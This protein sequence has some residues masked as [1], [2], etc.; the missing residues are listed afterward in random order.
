MPRPRKWKRVCSLP[1][2]DMFGPLRQDAGNRE[3]L[4]MS[5]EEFETI[6]LIDQEGLT[7]DEAAL[8][9]DVARGTVQRLYSDARFKLAETLVNG[10]LLKIE[11]GDYRLYPDQESRRGCGQCRRSR[12]GRRAG[13]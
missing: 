12:C 8:R 3:V 11:G 9:M 13:E 2:S 1:E 7:Q 10:S 4:K 5:V 6:R